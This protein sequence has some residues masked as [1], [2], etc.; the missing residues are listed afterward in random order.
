MESFFDP[1]S[2]RP[3]DSLSMAEGE[4]RVIGLKKF[5]L[6]PLQVWVNS[7]DSSIAAA[8]QVC[9]L[10]KPKADYNDRYNLLEVLTDTHPVE[11]NDNFFFQIAGN[12]AGSANITAKFMPLSGSSAEYA[13]PVRVSVT[14]SNKKLI[15]HPVGHFD[16]IWACHPYV[17]KAPETDQF[18]FC[19]DSHLTC[20]V[21]LCSALKKAGVSLH[22]LHGWKCAFSANHDHKHH[23]V[24]PY[25][26]KDWKG[27]SN[28]FV[29]QVTPHQPEP[30]PGMAAFEFVRA[31]T[32]VILFKNYWSINKK[33]K[34]STGGHIDLWNR[35]RMGNDVKS[36]AANPILT[37]SA[38]ARSEKIEFWP[39]D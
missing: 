36:A 33:D 38:F 30:M 21:R 23:F 39:V 9:K 16:T 29:W 31:K 34:F 11:A 27:L 10:N 6:R 5:Q 8:N 12:G 22:G 2:G 18:F 3:I 7:D 14:K 26:F 13:G 37:E 32:G 25:N 19:K 35:D 28:A 24:N 17:T 4:T 15:F 1:R 20:M